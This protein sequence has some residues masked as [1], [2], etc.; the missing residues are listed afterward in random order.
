MCQG[1]DFTAGNGTGGE[2]IYDAKFADENFMEKHT[3]PKVLSM[4]NAGLGTN[5][6]QFFICTAKTDCVACGLGYFSW[7]RNHEHT[8]IKGETNCRDAISRAEQLAFVI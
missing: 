2:S 1:G 3:G 7:F 4:A 5:G 6:S 8:K